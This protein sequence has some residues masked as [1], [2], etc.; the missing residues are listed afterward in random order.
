M[1]IADKLDENGKKV[2]GKSDLYL[3][4]RDDLLI[5]AIGPN[6]KDALKKAVASKPADVGVFRAQVSHV[7]DRAADRGQRPGAGG[8][9][10]GGREGVRQGRGRKADVLKV[11]IDGGDSLKIKITAQ[12]KAIQFLAEVGAGKKEQ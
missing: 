9:P 12:G 11:S 5:V 7:A 1:A 8:G 3:T 6:A 10:G 4:F 2:F